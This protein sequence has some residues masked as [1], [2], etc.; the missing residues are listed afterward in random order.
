MTDVLNDPVRRP[1]GDDANE[2]Q[3]ASD[4]LDEDQAS[5]PEDEGKEEDHLLDFYARSVERFAFESLSGGVG[6]AGHSDVSGI[7]AGRDAVS[8]HYY[9]GEREFEVVT[10][11]VPRE[12]LD[13]VGAIYVE[14]TVFAKAESILREQ[15]VLVL[16]GPAR[17]GKRTTALRLLD[18]MEM[19]EIHRVR[20]DMEVR[21]LA[22]FEFEDA[23]GYV[24]DTLAPDQA[25]RLTD[26][27]LEPMRDRLR[28]SQG[29]LAITV[30]ARSVLPHELSQSWVVRCDELPDAGQMVRRRLHARLDGTTSAQLLEHPRMQEWVQT[31]PR[32]HQVAERAAVLS[33]AIHDELSLDEALAQF[34]EDVDKQINVLLQSHTTC[35]ERAFLISLAVFDGG[36]YQDVLDGAGRLEALFQKIEEPD[37]PSGKQIFATATHAQL[38]LARA[39]RMISEEHRS[40]GDMPVEIV[41]FVDPRYASE[42]L[43]TVWRQYGSARGP[44]LTWLKG[45]AAHRDVR[46]RVRAAMA[47]GMLSTHGFGCILDEVLRRWASAPNYRQRQSVASMLAI[48]ALDPAL[49]RVVRALLREWSDQDSGRWR[50]L[51][52]ATAYGAQVGTL[53]PDAALRG[54]ERIATHNDDDL[55]GKVVR[56]S[57]TNLFEAGYQQTT[58]DALL[59]WTAAA[60]GPLERSAHAVRA[61]N[62]LRCFLRIAGQALFELP[63]QQKHWPPLLAVSYGDPRQMDRLVTLWRRALRTKTVNREA[64]DVLRGWVSSADED[65]ELRDVLWR[66]V[67]ELAEAGRARDRLVF[68]LEEWAP[69]SKA[70]E[71]LLKKLKQRGIRYAGQR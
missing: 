37:L 57:V 43:E 47:I 34:D 25:R 44:I 26:S 53:F 35:A 66:L 32:P 15:R 69:S 31:E 71:D 16:H 67:G 5:A 17:W 36:S 23:C 10:G 68:S 14:P 2:P 11:T 62:G 3:P 49:D 28:G 8:Y 59:A 56:S 18:V 46:V 22:S 63:A 38:E 40:V 45:L 19:R 51:T 1:D 27:W 24:V 52:A 20:P 58:L 4:Q 9:G 41:R 60:D 6:F 65:P 13:E 7:V 39:R 30:D 12:D 21:R 48:P 50:K 54:L 33:R 61:Q 70:A 42:V 55:V 64:L 29:Y